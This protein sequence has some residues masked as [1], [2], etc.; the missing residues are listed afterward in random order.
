L[1]QTIALMRFP[2]RFHSY[3]HRRYGETFTVRLVPA[4][5]PLV[6]FTRPED[7]REIFAGDPEVF[8]AGKGNAMLAPVMGEH[9]L[10]LQDSEEHKRARKRMTPAFSGQALREY[11]GMISELAVAEVGQWEPGSEFRSMDRMTTLIQE[12]VL[13]VVFG[14]S[15]ETRLAA[16]RPCVAAVADIS[17]SIVLGWSYPRLQRLGPWRRA[18][19]NQADLDRLIYAE[20]GDRRV[21]TDLAYRTDVLSRLLR[22]DDEKS[23]DHPVEGMS[24]TELRD[25]LVTLLLAGYE[26]TA[27]ALSWA[28]YE[29]G[30]CPHLMR[31]T[32]RAADGSGA[33]DDAWLGAI[34][35]E[36]LRLHPVFHIAV[37]TLMEDATVGGVDLPAGSSVAPSIVVAHRASDS[38]PDPWSFRP[39]RFIDGSPPANT[40]IPF[41]GGA[42]R[43]IGAGLTIVEGVAVLREVFRRFNVTALVD[44]EPRVHNITTGPKHGVRVRITARD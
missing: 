11:R 4:G 39:E 14:V 22:V 5:R 28:L 9:S 44:D 40:W 35:K 29:L 15:D 30:R 12:V 20:I 18:A 17:P 31:R 16:M 10:V 8:H 36:S 3:L 23:D 32:Q 34:V 37:R 21:A 26:T 24:D 27:I 42:R 41:G 1:V 38:H 7:V 2:Y 6:L 43:C 13:R 25:Q 19:A 33:E